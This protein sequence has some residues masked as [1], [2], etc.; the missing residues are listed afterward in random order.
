MDE[1]GECYICR[2]ENKGNTISY[3]QPCLH[4]KQKQPFKKCDNTFAERDRVKKDELNNSKLKFHNDKIERSKL[5]RH[6]RIHANER[7]YN[8]DFCDKCFP[9]NGHRKVHLRIHTEEKPYSWEICENTF[10]VRSN[11]KTHLRIHTEEKPYVCEICNKAHSQRV[12]LKNHLRIH[13]KE[14]PYVCEICE[15]A[16]SVRSSLRIHLLSHNEKKPF[17]CKI[18]KTELSE[19]FLKIWINMLAPKGQR[20]LTIRRNKKHIGT[21]RPHRVCMSY[22]VRKLPLQFQMH[23]HALNLSYAM[24]HYYSYDEEIR[25]LSMLIFIISITSG[26]LANV[27]VSLGKT[28]GNAVSRTIPVSLSRFD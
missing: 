24:A 13:T 8:C 17:T 27:H 25:Y 21:V 15:K 23:G 7:P 6:L 12:H 19:E 16:F 28:C 26:I 14:K 18:F 10:S 1:T 3:N 5:K 4:I 20:V 11:L 9:Q 2:E 22:P